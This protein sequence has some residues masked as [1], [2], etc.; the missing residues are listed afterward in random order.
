MHS[1]I[2]DEVVTGLDAHRGIWPRIAA[3]TDVPYSTLQ[4]IAQG[5]RKN[6][7]VQTVIALRDWLKQNLPP[8][9]AAG[10]VRDGQMR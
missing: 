5:Q 2:L 3:E 4:K 7:R 1:S 10:G 6:P 9:Q 8:Q